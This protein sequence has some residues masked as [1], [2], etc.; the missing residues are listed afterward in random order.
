MWLLAQ[1]IQGQ[2][3]LGVYSPFLPWQKVSQARWT[4]TVVTPNTFT[5]RRAHKHIIFPSEGQGGHLKQK[6]QLWTEGFDAGSDTST[7]SPW[8]SQTKPNQQAAS[9]SSIF[10]LHF[11]PRLL[12][13][14]PARLSCMCSY[15]IK[16][17]PLPL[18]HQFDF[19]CFYLFCGVQAR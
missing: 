8:G 4:Q 6:K 18:S 3:F 12:L 16:F 7:C 13:P 5:T 17:R 1:G 9:Y 14:P 2:V 10:K 19:R 15:N 11:A